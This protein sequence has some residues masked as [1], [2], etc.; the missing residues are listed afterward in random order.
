MQLISHLFFTKINFCLQFIKCTFNFLLTFLIHKYLWVSPL[1]AVL[2]FGAQ[3]CQPSTNVNRSIA[4]DLTT[5][6]QS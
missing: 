6:P 5:E 1:S 3:N 4:L 2:D